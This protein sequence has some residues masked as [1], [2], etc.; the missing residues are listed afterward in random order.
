MKIEV[1][2]L[3]VFF[4]VYIFAQQL[5]DQVVFEY[6]SA[7]NQTYRGIVIDMT[8]GVR[9]IGQP[10]AEVEGLGYEESKLKYYPN[11]VE[12]VLFVEWDRFYK[13][14]TSISIYTSNY[15]VVLQADHLV[16]ESKIEFYFESLPKGSYVMVVMYQDGTKESSTIIK[17]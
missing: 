11:P 9:S 2:L 15:Q 10:L 3:T 5:P 14:V 12:H 6:D 1:I 13:G 4:P 17:R 8:T 7:G 16:F